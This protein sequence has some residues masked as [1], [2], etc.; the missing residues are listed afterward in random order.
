MPVDRLVRFSNAEARATPLLLLAQLREIDATAELVYVGHGT[1]WLGAV[2]T[3]DE[4]RK[5][6]E[7]ILAFESK[8]TNPNPRNVM[9]GQL[10]LEGFAR[11][12]AYDCA[13]D[14]SVDKVVD[15]DGY[16][17]SIV[18]DFRARDRAWHEDQGRAVFKERLAES[19]GEPKKKAADLML[20]DYLRNDGREK[21]RRE[22]RDR[23]MFGAAGMTGGSISRRTLPGRII[24]LDQL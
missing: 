1:W 9:L 7:F 16:V 8:R 4:R 13:G 21:Y 6:G 11:I 24:T 10:L 14:P 12:Q 15:A 2:R 18:E 20:R 17:C 23:V 3:N 5:S 19:A 22:I